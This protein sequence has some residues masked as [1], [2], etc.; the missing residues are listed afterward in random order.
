MLRLISIFYLL[1]VS[2]PLI[3][4]QTIYLFPPAETGSNSSLDAQG[5]ARAECLRDL[6][7]A[8]S[9]FDIGYVL[10]ADSNSSTSP[11]LPPHSPSHAPSPDHHSGTNTPRIYPSPINHNP[12]RPLPQPNPRYRLRH[13]QNLHHHPPTILRRPR[14]RR[15][16]HR[17]RQTGHPN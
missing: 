5:L 4:A 15:Q 11:L 12:P 8:D 17:L 16:R 7:G 10:A 13:K 9:T 1:C 6:F 2:S 3:D 14:P